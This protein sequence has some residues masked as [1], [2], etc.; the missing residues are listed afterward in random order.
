MDLAKLSRAQQARELARWMRKQLREEAMGEYT[1][2]VAA[3]V[4]ALEREAFCLE[5]EGGSR[6]KRRRPRLVFSRAA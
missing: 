4:I 6:R 1:N 5:R 3:T 2:V